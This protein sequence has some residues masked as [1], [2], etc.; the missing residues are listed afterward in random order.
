[1]FLNYDVIP[2]LKAVLTLANSTDP[3]ER[4]HDA[5]FI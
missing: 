1:M 3:G 2:P 4:Q 5:A